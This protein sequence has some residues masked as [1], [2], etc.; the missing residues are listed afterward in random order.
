MEDNKMHY[1]KILNFFL[2]I[3]VLIVIQIY[4]S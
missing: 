3:T 2:T 1:H 4:S